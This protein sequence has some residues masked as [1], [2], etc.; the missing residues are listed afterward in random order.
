MTNTIRTIVFIA[1][2][3]VIGAPSIYFDIMIKA[4]LDLPVNIKTV[5]LID[6]STSENE[7]VNLLEKGLLST[8]SGKSDR[9]SK[10]CIDGIFAQLKDRNSLHH[11]P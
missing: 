10:S 4:S 8:I 5:A 7:V 2:F 3:I 1:L 11:E 6:M 9:I